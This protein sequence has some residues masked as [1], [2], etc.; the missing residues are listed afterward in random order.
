MDLAPIPDVS[1]IING[2]APGVIVTQGS[3]QVGSG[4]N[5]RIRGASS[6]SLGNQPLIY[7]DGVRLDNT[8]GAGIN[9]QGFG[10]GI[11]NRL[12]DVNPEDIE[13]I[14]IIKGPAAATLYGTE[15][16]NGVIQ[17][18]TK[19]GKAGQSDIT[20]TTRQGA[21]WF[22]NAE[23]RIRKNWAYE[24]GTTTPFEQN[25]FA[26]E[27]ERGNPPI[28]ETGRLQGYGASLRGGSDIARYFV[29]FDV[30]LDEGIEPDNTLGRYST[31]ANMTVNPSA[32]FD[33]TASIGYQQG[34][35][36]L[37]C[38]AGCG[39]RMWATVYA[40]AWLRDDPD[41]RGFRSYPP[42]II[43]EAFDFWQDLSRLQYSLQMNH[44]PFNW[45]AQRL[46]V[47]QD[48]VVENNQE[49]AQRLDPDRFSPYFG[50]F[51]LS[52]YKWRQDR[53]VNRWTFDY[54]ATISASL[55]RSIK[56]STTFGAQYF[57]LYEERLFA[58]GDEFPAPGLKVIDAAAITYGGDWHVENNTLGFFV[59]ERLAF[60]DRIFLTGA[61]RGDD[62]SAFGRNYDFVLYPKLS[63]TWVINEESFWNI[64][65][66]D[67]LKLRAAYGTSGQ[68][69]G[70]FDAVRT[71]NPV[72][73]GN[74]R[75][76][77]T[78]SVF[79]NDS[80]GPEVGKEFE[81]GFEAG[82]FNSR[83]GVDFT[84]YHTRTSDAILSQ[85][86]APSSGFPG[87][88]FVNAGTIQNQGFE[89]QLSAIAVQSEN[90]GIDFTLNLATNANKILDLGGVDQGQGFLAAGSQM[91]VPGMPV[92]AYFD[93][94]TLSA[95]LNGTGY[96]ARTVNPMCDSGNPNGLMRI[97]SLTGEETPVE[98]GGDPVTCPGPD[99]PRLYLG[100]AIPTFE[101]SF[102]TTI[103]L[104]K[105][106]RLY[107]MMDW[108]T[109]HR[110]FDNNARVRQAVFWSSRENFFPEEYDPALIAEMQSPNVLRSF[111]F[112][113]ASY[114]KLRE[115]SLTWTIPP[116]FVFGAKRA[117]IT[118]AGRNLFI[119]SGYSGL[120][121]EA[122][123]LEFGYGVL[124]QDNTPQLAQFVTTL[125][126]TF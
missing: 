35:I 62:N 76:A 99:A 61:V 20:L 45:L 1:N 12:N 109:G 98:L 93:E 111:V 9:V 50:S 18:I 34:R 8:M 100:N 104:F 70:F 55:A 40:N 31:R 122:E 16:S 2:R 7:V 46:T 68:Q 41:F 120:D 42:E 49:M 54:S 36:G 28:F 66:V 73:G 124:E 60:N 117:S 74:G 94:K 81:V 26:L 77:A 80:L 37:A 3:G 83:L 82:L 84:Y 24:P 4:P 95:T 6:F 90:L 112:S 72:T 92:A 22:A 88:Q 10:S 69:P 79:G 44:R 89:V 86:L 65:W 25:L 11:V 102:A 63:A 107:A 105:N 29:A 52:G 71:Y 21:N 39:G 78:P 59:Q 121:P 64:G 123:F 119:I 53:Q 125:N 30:D 15:A 17:I 5:I 58:E 67:A 103:T 113:N 56:S 47:G 19:S 116:R 101:G 106:F 85:S 118:V 51:T 43:S 114:A 23:G 126:I 14:E 115:L 38:E 96:D 91:R 108:K 33:L 57:K 32:A 48:R 110:K 97:N 75:P 27:R 87:S 13:S